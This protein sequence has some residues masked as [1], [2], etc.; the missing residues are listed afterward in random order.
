MTGSNL[1]GDCVATMDEIQLINNDIFSTDICRLS[2]SQ[3]V[4]VDCSISTMYRSVADNMS[5]LEGTGG[6]DTSFCLVTDANIGCSHTSLFE[7]ISPSLRLESDQSIE[8]ATNSVF[9]F[10]DIH[11]ISRLKRWYICSA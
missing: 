6:N 3:L 8:E 1:H 5:V 7:N 2:D 4:G 11:V 10:S 9:R